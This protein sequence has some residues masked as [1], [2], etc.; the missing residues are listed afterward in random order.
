MKLKLKEEPAEWLKFTAV[1]ALMLA[2]VAGLLFRRKVITREVFGGVIV[3]L[4]LAPL[5]CWIRPG[6]FRGFYRGGMTVSFQFGQAMG[7]VLLAIFFLLVV[8]PLGLL[9]RLMGKDLLRLK[10]RRDAITYWEPA[11]PN[12]QFDRQF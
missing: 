11:K 3:V 9:L 1:M 4:L 10:R 2:L 7:Q 8:T 5:V 12:N 6:W